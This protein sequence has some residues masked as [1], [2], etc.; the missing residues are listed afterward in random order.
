M[1]PVPANTPAEARAYARHLSTENP[2][3]YVTLFTC[4]GIF[5]TVADRLHVF[6]PT[7]SYG[8]S[9]WLNGKEK[10]FTSAQRL[11]DQMATPTGCQ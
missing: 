3:K 9:Y 4:F 2:G 8:T 10:T 5:A 1:I 11:A 7:D 6:A